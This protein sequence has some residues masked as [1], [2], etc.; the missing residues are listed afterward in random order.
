MKA[1]R[2]HRHGGPEVL[3]LD[4]V[5][6]PPCDANSVIVR[7]DWAGVNY[8]DIYHREGTY[9]VSLP[10]IPGQEGA[11]VIDEV[12]ENVTD[13]AVGDRVAWAG[14][15][16]G[17]AERVA[18]SH[19]RLVKLP[20]KLPT[21]TGAAIMLQGL[22]AHYLTT[23]VHAVSPGDTVLVHAGAGGVGRL[24]IQMVHRAG[25][26]VFGT[27]SSE[28]KAQRVLD[29]GAD[30]VI[31]YDYESVSERVRDL[32]NGR[33][34]N[35]VYDGVGRATWEESLLSA[36]PRATVA[37]FGAASGQ[38]PPFDLQRLSALGS[39][40]VTRPTL[41][42]FIQTREELRWRADE[43]F[44]A[45]TQNLLEVT[46]AGEYELAAAAR[47]HTDLASRNFSGK[48]LLRAHSPALN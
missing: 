4:T 22:T 13:F 43:L 34:V 35:A 27:T 14:V 41:S 19:N 44:Q 26:T 38:V 12:G 30:A 8:I 39:L 32:T 2:L 11:G 28:E 18:V 46:V 16:S 36:A 25:A 33:G 24:L 5:D 20:A 1:I 23:S 7:L 45:V 47:A 40:R 15:P 42:D 3:Q 37:L 10:F 29:A 9:P 17:Y 48:L 21:H 6:D 31:R